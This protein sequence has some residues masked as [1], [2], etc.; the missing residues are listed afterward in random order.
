[1]C[2]LIS[3]MIFLW[4]ID[5]IANLKTISSFFYFKSKQSKITHCHSPIQL[6]TLT[7]ISVYKRFICRCVLYN[8]SLLL[9]FVLL[10]PVLAFYL[11]CTISVTFVCV[12]CLLQHGCLFIMSLVIQNQCWR[13][14]CYLS[15]YNQCQRSIC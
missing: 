13:A 14:F 7:L 3:L 11:S 6:Y 5:A 12:T 9:L 4:L 10:Q 8:V 1:M 15:F 2:L